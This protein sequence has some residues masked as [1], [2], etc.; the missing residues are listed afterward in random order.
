MMAVL[1]TAGA[2]SSSGS[3]PR[4][5]A[6]TAPT[7]TTTTTVFSA[8]CSRAPHAPGATDN[9]LVVGG[10]E[11]RYQLLLPASYDGR[12][13]LPVVFALH[14]LTVDYHFAPSI[15]GFEAVTPKYN[16]IGVAPSGRLDGTTP[17]WQA[18]PVPARDDYDVQF[19]SALLD[20][21]ERDLCIDTARVYSTGMSNGGQMSSALACRLAD[22]LTAVAPVAGVEFFSSCTGRPVPVIAFHGVKDPIVGYDGGGLNATQIADNQLWKGSKPAGLP[23]HR[24]VDAAL[25][26]W[27]E[28]NGCD[29]QPVTK[30]ISAEVQH[31]TWRH[32]DADTELY[33]VDNGGH[34]WPGR[35]VPGFADQFGHTTT[36][37][38]ATQLIF[39]FFWAHPPRA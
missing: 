29:P 23:Q 35:P 34:S 6:P 20:K 37:V 39:T 9:T 15:V 4:P 8:G 28:H 19:I 14:A 10:V 7:S 31:R 33:I 22:R 16:F 32:C 17:F 21:L 36:D 30:R 25:Q 13:P 3:S 24:G 5:T 27:A 12:T 11:R 26:T 1:L 2:C 38:D 18:A